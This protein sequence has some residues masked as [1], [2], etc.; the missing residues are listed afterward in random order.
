LKGRDSPP[1]G[2]PNPFYSGTLISETPALIPPPRIP[3]CC[4]TP[5]SLDFFRLSFLQ[6]FKIPT[7]RTSFITY[8]PSPFLIPC[9]LFIFPLCVNFPFSFP[10]FHP[11]ERGCLLITGFLSFFSLSWRCNCLRKFR[12]GSLSFAGPPPMP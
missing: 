4:F 11:Y 12:Q 10:Q 1:Y 9:H 5:P 8:T 2:F 3:S 6:R 7:P